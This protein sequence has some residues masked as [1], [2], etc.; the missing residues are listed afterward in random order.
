M[1]APVEPEVV[2]DAV[3][4]AA[5]GSWREYWLGT[6]TLLTIL[7]NTVLPGYLDRYLAKKGIKGQ[8]TPA[9]VDVER[10]DNLDQPVPALH[11]TRG[12]F[13]AEAGNSALLIPG[14]VARLGVV[15]AGALIFFGLGALF[16][17]GRR[18]N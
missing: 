9:L 10:Q 18:S 17:Q 1:G 8:Q 3:F 14:E 5:H 7:G 11:R 12:S 15:A 2:A 6:P 13:S 16:A 4:R